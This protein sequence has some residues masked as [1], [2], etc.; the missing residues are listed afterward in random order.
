MNQPVTTRLQM[1]HPGT[2]W[3]LAGKLARLR[4]TEAQLKTARRKLAHYAANEHLSFMSALGLLPSLF[5]RALRSRY[6]RIVSPP[7]QAPSPHR[8]DNPTIRPDQL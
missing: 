4:E 3:T 1:V 2:L 6:R 5:V 7:D 8:Q